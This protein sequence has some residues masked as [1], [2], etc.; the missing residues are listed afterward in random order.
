MLNDWTMFALAVAQYGVDDTVWW[1][2][3]SGL[4]RVQRN[5]Y[6]LYGCDRQ[7]LFVR[8]NELH[9]CSNLSAS[10]MCN[11]YWMF[12]FGRNTCP[13]GKAE[14]ITQDGARST[15]D[16]CALRAVGKMSMCAHYT[17]VDGDT[18]LFVYTNRPANSYE[19]VAIEVKFTANGWKYSERRAHRRPASIYLLD[20]EKIVSIQYH[21]EYA[22][23]LYE[24]GRRISI[25]RPCLRR[26]FDIHDV[27]KGR[28][29]ATA[30]RYRLCAGLRITVCI[31]DE[32]GIIWKYKS[33]NICKHPRRLVFV[34]DNVIMACFEGEVGSK[35]M[36]LMVNMVDNTEYVVSM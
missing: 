31:L 19:M 22:E 3:S 25:S 32:R 36:F 26:D 24:C 6:E 7:M 34:S 29:L 20:G 28:C 12:V 10:P 4:A 18:Y 17:V 9:M 5:L 16:K 15:V 33:D 1:I 23:L 11:D 35:H 13:E 21:A 30:H 27:R 2:D 8:N 14:S